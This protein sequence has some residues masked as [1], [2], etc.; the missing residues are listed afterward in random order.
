MGSEQSDEAL[1]IQ[2][3]METEMEMLNAVKL[4]PALETDDV[5]I[6]DQRNNHRTIRQ[7]TRTTRRDERSVVGS[8]CNPYVSSKKK[9]HY[10]KSRKSHKITELPNLF[11]PISQLTSHQ[12]SHL[13]MFKIRCRICLHGFLNEKEKSAHEMICPFR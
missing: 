3:D 2:D 1:V 9:K 7:S 4:E 10:R 6:I 5:L 13:E 12:K 8:L 11:G